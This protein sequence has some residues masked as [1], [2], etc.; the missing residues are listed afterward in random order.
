MP[1]TSSNTPI[2]RHFFDYC[3][4]ANHSYVGGLAQKQALERFAAAEGFALG[5]LYVEVETGK[6]ADAIDRRPQLRRQKCSR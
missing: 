1:A 5:R 2:R 3:A 4:A 6:G